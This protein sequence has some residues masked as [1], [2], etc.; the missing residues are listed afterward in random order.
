MAVTEADKEQNT[1]RMT[2]YLAIIIG[3]FVG[4]VFGYAGSVKEVEGLSFLDSLMTACGRITMQGKLLPV[5]NFA[6]FR[7]FVI[8]GLLTVFFTYLLV[9]IDH[10]KKRHFKDDD[11]AGTGRFMTKKEMEAY[12][13]EYILSDPPVIS[14]NLPVPYDPDHDKDRY[15]KNMIMSKHF[16]RPIDERKMD[17]NNNVL[18]VGA[19]GTGKS[20][21]VVK[22]N[23]LQMNA[24]YVITDPSGEM[25]YS[26][27]KVLKDHGYKIKIFNISDM[28]HSNCYNPLEYIRDEA[29]VKMLT[30][31]LIRNTQ[32]GDGGGDNQFFTDAEQLLYSAC[33]FYLRD[34]NPDQRWVNFAG[35][36]HL[37]NSF[38]N[39]VEQN[40]K[41]GKNQTEAQKKKGIDKLFNDLPKTSLAWKYYQ[42]FKK[43]A[44][45]TLS[46][47]LISCTTRLQPFLIP[48]V[49]NLTS[50]DELDLA[51]FGNEKTALFIITPQADRTYSFLASML[52]HQL[53]E[54]LYYVGERQKQMTGSEQ[55][56]IPVRCVMDEFA[57]IGEVPDFPS[58]LSTMRK[59]NISAT[60]I[61]QNISQIEA[62][63]KDDWKTLVGNCSS[64]IFL[65]SSEPEV[66]KYF[67]EALGKMTIRSR[68]AGLTNGGKSNASQNFSP[69]AREVMTAE[70]LG[71]LPNG[72][73][74]VLTQGMRP[75]RDEKYEYKDHLYF[76]QTADKD[77]ANAFI[78]RDSFDFDTKKRQKY[79]SVFYAQQEAARYRRMAK[80]KKPDEISLPVGTSVKSDP[81]E[82]ER[83]F[84]HLQKKV[85][86][87][88]KD[89]KCNHVFAIQI[90]DI[91]TELFV[92][93]VMMSSIQLKKSML[94]IFSEYAD[95]IIAVGVDHDSKKLRDA[96]KN[97]Y[98]IET[99]EGK[100]KVKEAKEYQNLTMVMI[101]KENLAEYCK[102][103]D[104]KLSGKTEE[105]P[106]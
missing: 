94:I 72:E 30:E 15:S 31:C 85:L 2:L 12:A 28:E 78:Y 45:K 44:D 46:S 52:Y 65:G 5:F 26:V 101:E 96:M 3:F 103:L 74:I 47:I 83:T 60:V 37:I 39:P 43:A 11:V 84:I 29:G 19:A 10:D 42:A 59:Y 38:E 79:A 70:E 48:Q 76:D 40:A 102:T 92:R 20:R 49:I 68:S 24:S 69:T 18:V 98:V 6:F 36:M 75:V 13:K 66:L 4:Y 67:S 90:P 86:L 33:I 64:I 81:M 58:R 51:N 100:E 9:S 97:G 1:K 17:G 57:N 61:L 53:F 82:L 71:R 77:E 56:K 41:K 35:V 27:G 80:E 22:P 54:T 50:S 88:M 93:L 105:K 21:F 7:N 104:E 87:S 91:P 89:S 25:I 73:C 99:K 95:K 63:Y 106:S 55:L 16:C 23:I 8:S 62:M 32:K 14:K 34:H